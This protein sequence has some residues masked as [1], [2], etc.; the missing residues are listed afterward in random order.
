MAHLVLYAAVIGAK[1]P[2]IGK[3]R[4]LFVQC[5]SLIDVKPGFPNVVP[6]GSAQGLH[7]LK[8]HRCH[9]GLETERSEPARRLP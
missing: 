3:G 8:L 9:P 5:P 4:R 2:I 1:V 7:L 6:F